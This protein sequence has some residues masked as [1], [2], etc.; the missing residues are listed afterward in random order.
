MFVLYVRHMYAGGQGGGAVPPSSP[1]Q[2]RGDY[3]RVSQPCEVDEIALTCDE[4][5]IAAS[6]ATELILKYLSVDK[7]EESVRREREREKDGGF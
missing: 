5:Y 2:P 4:R 7:S 3:M 6:G 1:G